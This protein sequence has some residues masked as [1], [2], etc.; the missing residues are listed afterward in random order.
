MTET[1]FSIIKEFM[2]VWGTRK[3]IPS[4]PFEDGAVKN[5]DR[6]L[7]KKKKLKLM[8]LCLSKLHMFKQLSSSLLKIK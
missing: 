2:R 1:E 6:P 4:L 5:D 3:S 8:L 7:K